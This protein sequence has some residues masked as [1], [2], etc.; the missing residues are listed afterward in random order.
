MRAVQAL[1]SL[2]SWIAIAVVVVVGSAVEVLLAVLT[3]PFD[4]RRYVCGRFF[5][6]M[7]VACA[8]LVPSWRFGVAGELPARIHPRTVV[9]SNHE[10]QA[11]PFLIS[12]LPWE[13]K[14]LSKE[15][16]FRV[17]LLGFC[18]SVAGDIPVK[19]G[20][21]DSGAE[22]MRRCAQW[23]DKGV[24]VMIF[25]E[26]T[27]SPDGNMLPFKEGAFRLAAETG[28]ELLPIAVDGTREALPK[29]SWKFGR[30]RARV[31]VGRPIPAKGVSPSDLSAAARAQIEELLRS[32]RTV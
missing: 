7:G 25:P 23:L 1:A 9:V 14:W 22:A 32:L 28:A 4:R 12:S 20:D 8:K 24:P 11:D 17:P 2:W 31:K 29:H 18:M 15:S 16:M 30:S 5:R 27:R 13:M 19:R 6:L 26:G 21:K 3:L 10:S